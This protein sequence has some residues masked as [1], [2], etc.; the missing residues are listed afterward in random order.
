LNNI[1]DISKYV[2]IRFLEHGRSMHSC[3]CW[4]LVYLYYKHE[5]GVDLPLLKSYPHTKARPEIAGIIEAE[6]LNW[7]K[8]DKSENIKD[9]DVIVLNISGFPAHVGICVGR[10]RMLH[11]YQGTDSCIESFT[12]PRWKNRIEGVYRY[13]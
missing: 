4:G 9:G 8:V 11:A 3:D 2:G 10:G 1:S 7:S 5:L 12:G 13:E 6:K